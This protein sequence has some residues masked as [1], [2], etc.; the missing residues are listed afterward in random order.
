MQ[1]PCIRVV[2]TGVARMTYGL[3][4]GR[5]E[6]TTEGKRDECNKTRTPSRD[7]RQSRLKIVWKLYVKTSVLNER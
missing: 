6:G 7:I 2:V 1:C 5:G 3:Q 4:N